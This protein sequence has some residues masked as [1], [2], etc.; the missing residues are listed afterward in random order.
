MGSL[1]PVPVRRVAVYELMNVTRQE[2]AIVITNDDENGMRARLLGPLPPELDL[3]NVKSDDVS[4]QTL[5][6]LLKEN[7][8]EEFVKT[9]LESMLQ[10]TWRFHVWRP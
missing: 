10:K 6:P 9:Y 4:V 3:W 1:T 5:S 7:L 8:A 2:S